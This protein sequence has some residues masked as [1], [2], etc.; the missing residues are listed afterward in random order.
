[1]GRDSDQRR[2]HH[3]ASFLNTERT[4]HQEARGADGV[5]QARHDHGVARSDG[6]AHKP[7][8]HKNLHRAQTPC[9]E[10][11]GRAGGDPA[12]ILVERSDRFIHGQKRRTPAGAPG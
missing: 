1:M 8:Q 12:T 3:E 5:S 2:E 7:Q 9:R 6:L 11:E 10:M 4:R